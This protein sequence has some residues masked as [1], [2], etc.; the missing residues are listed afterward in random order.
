MKKNQLQR[1][2]LLWGKAHFKMN[3]GPEIV[4]YFE[5]PMVYPNLVIADDLERNMKSGSLI[6]I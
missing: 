6:Q 4:L 3:P 1:N 5:I 2:L